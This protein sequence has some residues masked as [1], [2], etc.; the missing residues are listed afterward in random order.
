MCQTKINSIFP[1]NP[2]FRNSGFCRNCFLSHVFGK[3]SELCSGMVIFWNYLV[4]W[5]GVWKSSED[6]V[7]VEL[8][9]LPPRVR[10]LIRVV[11]SIRLRNVHKDIQQSTFIKACRNIDTIRSNYIAKSVWEA[12]NNL[13]AW[14]LRSLRKK[15]KLKLVL[16]FSGRTTK[17]GGGPRP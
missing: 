9:D 1:I 15:L 6:L 4:Y 5:A 7:D 13:V 10:L 11:R 3:I 8:P 16:F 12:T 14:P 2:S 17:R